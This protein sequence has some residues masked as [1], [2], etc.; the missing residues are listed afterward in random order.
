MYFIKRQE[1]L[2]SF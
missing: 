2:I 1:G